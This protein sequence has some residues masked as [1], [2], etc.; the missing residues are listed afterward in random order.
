MTDIINNDDPARVPNNNN[1]NNISN[2]SLSS[3]ISNN[4]QSVPLNNNSNF[5]QIATHNVRGLMDPTK[6]K[7]L[8]HTMELNN[9]DILSLSETNLSGK[10]AKYSLRNPS[11]FSMEMTSTIF[12]VRVSA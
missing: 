10:K 11:P 9:I 2:S 12:T 3:L 4:I 8:L 5:F 6:Q 1:I 7:N